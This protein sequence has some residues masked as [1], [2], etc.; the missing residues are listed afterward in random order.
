MNVTVIALLMGRTF[1][2][3]RDE[4]MDL[5]VGALMPGIGKIQDA[6]RLRADEAF[7]SAEVNTTAST[8]PPRASAWA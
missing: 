8:S 6:D 3:S 7:T 4:M 5:G 1:G 2:M